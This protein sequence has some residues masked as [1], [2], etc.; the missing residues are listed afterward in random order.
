[1]SAGENNEG[2]ELWIVAIDKKFRNQGHG[3]QMILGIINQFKGKNLMLFARCAP[4]SE[5]MY[6][7]LL[8]HGFNHFTTGQEGYRGLMYE[9]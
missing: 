7:L 3:K 4:E 6:Q 8:Q 9:L 1:M 5:I 2:N